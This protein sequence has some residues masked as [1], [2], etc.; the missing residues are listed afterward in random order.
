MKHLLPYIRDDV[1]T[2]PANLLSP[3]GSA[4]QRTPTLFYQAH[5][6]RP[7]TMDLV[8]EGFDAYVFDRLYATLL[9]TQNLNITS[10]LASENVFATAS[11]LDNYDFKPASKYLSFPPS[12]YA[13][14]ST[15]PRENIWRQLISL[16]IITWFV[17]NCH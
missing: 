3:P 1:R 10:Q 7:T 16:Y 8:L 5:C 2:V 13:C 9:P 12:E 15:L 17:H 11:C 14:M 6:S 4:V